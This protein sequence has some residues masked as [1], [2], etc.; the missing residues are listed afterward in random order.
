MDSLR[1][2]IP[3]AVGW[4]SFIA[5]MLAGFALL[6]IPIPLDHEA[7]KEAEGRSVEAVIAFTCAFFLLLI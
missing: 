1:Y 4:F 7:N 6:S 3:A 2:D 5:G